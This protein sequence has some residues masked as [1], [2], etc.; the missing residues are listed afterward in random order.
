MV[1]EAFKTFTITSTVITSY[2][3]KT[4]LYKNEEVLYSG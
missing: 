3:K 1:L 4:I 2:Y